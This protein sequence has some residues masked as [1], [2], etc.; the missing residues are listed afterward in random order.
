MSIRKLLEND[1][2][3]ARFCTL[4]FD[5]DEHAEGVISN[6][7]N[8][9]GCH[10]EL[11]KKLGLP[12]VDGPGGYPYERI[13]LFAKRRG[14]ITS[15]MEETSGGKYY[16]ARPSE[17]FKAEVTK[18]WGLRKVLYDCR[19]ELEKLKNADSIEMLELMMATRPSLRL[20]SLLLI[21]LSAAD[22]GPI[23][24]LDIRTS[25]YALSEKYVFRIQD[26]E[27]SKPIDILFVISSL[28]QLELMDV[29]SSKEIRPEDRKEE[30]K[31]YFLK[32]LEVTPAERLMS[33]YEKYGS[34]YKTE[35]QAFLDSR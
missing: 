3:L 8:N 19:T 14:L 27:I 2:G 13:R 25:S 32:L 1:H 7:N 20:Y 9:G 18:D 33:W 11:S 26:F 17:K 4:V 35:L 34:Q 5:L 10:S 24:F 29:H 31:G 6:N 28:C 15:Q 16:V 23:E 22:D 12:L 21:H 30:S